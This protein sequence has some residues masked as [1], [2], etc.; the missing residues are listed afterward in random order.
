MTA[1]PLQGRKLTAERPLHAASET[2]VCVSI[3]NAITTAVMSYRRLSIAP[4]SDS[5]SAD[6]SEYAIRITGGSTGR[7]RVPSGL[8]RML[9][10]VASL[11]HAR[12]LQHR[13][14]YE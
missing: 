7:P 3:I 13:T 1:H 10:N 9:N 2:R 6:V 4:S 14:L 11:I 8:L 12:G 5:D